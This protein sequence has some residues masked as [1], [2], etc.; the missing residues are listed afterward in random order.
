MIDRRKLLR[1]TEFGT[2]VSV[3]LIN[4]QNSFIK[5]SFR[6]SFCETLVEEG[7]Q[8]DVIVAQA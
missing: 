7:G 6:S 4:I 3:L 1:F 2:Q 5:F 8:L